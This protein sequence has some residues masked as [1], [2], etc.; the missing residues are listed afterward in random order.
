MGDV[1]LTA[2]LG[3]LNMWDASVITPIAV[4]LV[5]AGAITGVV[6]LVVKSF[7]GPF[8]RLHDAD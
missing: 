6:V 5:A 8:A 1:V 4:Y 2:E 3:R 7:S